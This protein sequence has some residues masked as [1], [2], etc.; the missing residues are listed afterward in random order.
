MPRRAR[1]TSGAGVA[2]G[3]GRRLPA[4]RG[5]VARRRGDCRRRSRPPPSA[6]GDFIARRHCAALIAALPMIPRG[7]NAS[8]TTMMTKVK[9]TL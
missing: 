1:A 6:A 7:R 8:A 3:A 2:G 5:A 4:A 9:T